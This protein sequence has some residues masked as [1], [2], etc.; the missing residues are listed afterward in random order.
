MEHAVRKS[1]ESRYAYEHRRK[2]LVLGMVVALAIAV[3]LAILL[4][5]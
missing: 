5:G 3:A 1:V 2:T 4:V